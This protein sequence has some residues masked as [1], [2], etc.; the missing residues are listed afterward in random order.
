M[1]CFFKCPLGN[2]QF[3][4]RAFFNMSKLKAFGP[5][6]YPW[7]KPRISLNTSPQHQGKFQEP[8]LGF[9]LLLLKKL[10]QCW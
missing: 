2:N 9:K 4:I 8:K 5:L 7:Y 1:E 3:Y 10:L 6:S